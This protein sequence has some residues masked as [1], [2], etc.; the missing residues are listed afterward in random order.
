MFKLKRSKLLLLCST[1][2][3]GGTAAAITTLNN[4]G[5]IFSQYLLAET[6]PLSEAHLLFT[7]RL[8]NYRKLSNGNP[9]IENVKSERLEI[10]AD[11]LVFNLKSIPG[12]T[13][14]DDR[15]DEQLNSISS[16][17]CFVTSPLNADRYEFIYLVTAAHCIV[18]RDGV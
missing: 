17:T 6:V 10:I 16:G 14:S 11:Y 18:T 12:K 15:N 3:G 13:L 1:I 2:I 5:R 7:S 9:M 4:E 8:L